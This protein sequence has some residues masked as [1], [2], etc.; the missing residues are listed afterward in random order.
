MVSRV[1]IVVETLDNRAMLSKRN[2]KRL[3]FA[4]YA[5]LLHSQLVLLP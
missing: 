3:G 5:N 4:S 2:E 1:G